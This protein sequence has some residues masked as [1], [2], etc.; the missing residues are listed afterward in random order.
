MPI[1]IQV[2]ILINYYYL[3]KIGWGPILIW[4]YV[5]KLASSNANHNPRGI[6]LFFIEKW[7]EA[8]TNWMLI[9]SIKICCWWKC[10]SY[11]R[12]NLFARKNYDMK[13]LNFP[14]SIWKILTSLQQIIVI[15][16]FSCVLDFAGIL[17]S[18]SEVHVYFQAC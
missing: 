13:G 5:L 18:W 2:F 4:D 12:K 15:R 7:A 10:Q 6:N 1:I 3:F 8:N 11:P 17:S 14:M 16:L 9:S